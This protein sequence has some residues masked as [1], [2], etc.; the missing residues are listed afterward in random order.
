M[1]FDDGMIRWLVSEL[2][3]ERDYWLALV[4][5]SKDLVVVVMVVDVVVQV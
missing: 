5:I 1:R 2:M 3:C 4:S